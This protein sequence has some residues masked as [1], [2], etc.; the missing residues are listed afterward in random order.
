MNENLIAKSYPT[1]KI[2][3]Y[4]PN[5]GLRYV[6][7]M[8]ADMHRTLLKGGIFMNPMNKARPHAKLRLT[9][10]SKSFC[11]LTEQAG[12]KKQSVLAI[13]IRFLLHHN[14]FARSFA[15]YHGQ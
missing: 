8:V 3:K 2:S 1:R 4:M 9:Y 10:I 13:K 11:R 7:S 15:D 12:G 5:T 6:G 14:I